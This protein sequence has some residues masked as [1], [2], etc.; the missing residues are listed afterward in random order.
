MGREG[1]GVV[2]ADH[3]VSTNRQQ[4]RL[5][6]SF[7]APDDPPTFERY[8]ETVLWP[9]LASIPGWLTAER[10]DAFDAAGRRI[11]QPY[12]EIILTFPDRATLEESLRSDAGV[13]AG[14]T[15]SDLPEGAVRVRVAEAR[16][17]PRS[18]TSSASPSS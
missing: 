16:P 3:T 9:Q 11:S 12:V 10:Q 8:L 1:G 7:R 4:A 15:L 6:I 2:H 14:R 18:S 13:R 17:L 5:V